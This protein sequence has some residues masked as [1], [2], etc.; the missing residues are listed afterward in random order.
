MFGEVKGNVRVL[1]PIQVFKEFVERPSSGRGSA[2]EGDGP[3]DWAEVYAQER[4]KI[5]AL[6]GQ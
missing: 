6:A 4:E 5:R 2:L 1:L 3:F